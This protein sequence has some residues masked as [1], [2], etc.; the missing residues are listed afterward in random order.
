MIL[1]IQGTHNRDRF[2]N[3]LPHHKQRRE[4]SLEIKHFHTITE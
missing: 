3:T 1:K 4:K 2:K